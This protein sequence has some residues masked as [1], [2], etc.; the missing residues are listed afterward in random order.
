MADEVVQLA[1]EAQA[2]LGDGEARDVLAGGAQVGVRSMSRR[3]ANIMKPIASVV[4]VTVMIVAGSA[5]SMR[6][7][8]TVSAVQATIQP[9]AVRRGRRIA[10]EMPAKRKSID[11]PSRSASVMTIA[12][13]VR[14]AS[15]V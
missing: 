8:V 6:F 5:W 4:A 2:L 9:M 3:K 13:A 15:C 10:P 1:R 11:Q 7:V 14:T 12:S